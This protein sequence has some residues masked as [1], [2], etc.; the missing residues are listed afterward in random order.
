MVGQQG[1]GPLLSY[2][3][4]LLRVRGE[5]VERGADFALCRLWRQVAAGCAFQQAAHAVVGQPLRGVAALHGQRHS[6][7]CHHLEGFATAHVAELVAQAQQVEGGDDLHV[8]GQGGGTTGS[9]WA[10]A[11][12]CI[13]QQVLGEQAD[14]RVTA[15][16]FAEV[17][18]LGLVDAFVGQALAQ[19]FGQVLRQETCCLLAADFQRRPQPGEVRLGL[20]FVAQ[21]QAQEP[22]VLNA[23]ALK[24][25]EAEKA[26]AVALLKQRGNRLLAPIRNPGEVVERTPL[27]PW[28]ILT[29]A[30][31]FANEASYVY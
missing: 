21:E 2:R 28:E 25:A 19:G 10:F 23:E 29:H 5:K 18:E 11:A 14:Q 9:Q 12:E 16:Q 26:K 31:L 27:K 1:I 7:L 15:V 13:F 8:I 4:Q 17:D 6:F 24:K 20:K 3:L 30:L 22:K